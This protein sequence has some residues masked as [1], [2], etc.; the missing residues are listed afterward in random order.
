M[1]KAACIQING[2][3]IIEE[4]IAK[5]DKLIRAAVSDGAEFIL[6]PESSSMMH[7]TTK[8]L[9]E[10]ATTEEN[11][12]TL[13]FFRNIA[14]ELNIF[15]LI[16]SLSIKEKEDSE[17]LYNRSYMINSEGG[18]ISRYDKIHLYNVELAN[19]ETYE[20]SKNFLSGNKEVSVQLPFG[21]LGMTICYDLRFPHLFR[22]LAQ[23]GSDFISAPAAFIEFTG[24]AH[25]ET[26]LRARAIENGCYIIAP[27]Q[28]GTHATGRVTFGNSMII[29]PW[30]II[31]AKMGPEEGFVMADI[32]KDKVAEI[33]ASM[34]SLSHDRG[35]SK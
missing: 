21:K 24:K 20:E 34:P 1:T 19:G 15:I 28:T 6:T 16:G 30:G 10:N 2:S 33:R 8:E 23:S 31:L 14:K 18:I 32:N 26:L 7:K 13:K 29:D 17:K 22:D 4:N 12:I 3:N 9:F 5:F 27:A 25:W 35:Y 11:D